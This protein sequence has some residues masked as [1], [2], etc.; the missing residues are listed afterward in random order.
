MIW[1][2]RGRGFRNGLRKFANVYA[3]GYLLLE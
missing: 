1:G 3:G 2:M